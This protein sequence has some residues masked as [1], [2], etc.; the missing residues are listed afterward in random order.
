MKMPP[1]EIARE[2]E[3][4]SLVASND[5]ASRPWFRSGVALLLIVV[6]LGTILAFRGVGRWLVRE[7]PLSHADAIVVLSGSMPARAEEAAK[8]FHMSCAPEVWVSR[9]GSAGAELGKLGISYAGEEEYNRQILIHEGVPANA[10]RVFPDSIVD[11]EEEVEEVSRQLR[12]QNKKSVIIVTSPQH[13]RRAKALW[14]RLAE[15]NQTAIVRAAW[16]DN[17]DADH[18]WRNTRDAFSVVREMMGLAN[19]WAGLPVRPPAH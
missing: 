17:F 7:D 8:I 10:V 12:A 9:P 11:T 16:E 18:W 2:V 1:G 15:T 3:K 5:W 6:L 4:E 14:R 13:T 19:A